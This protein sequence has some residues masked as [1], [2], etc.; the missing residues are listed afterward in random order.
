MTVK[1]QRDIA[2]PA[3]GEIVSFGDFQVVAG[4]AGEG[5]IRLT[6]KGEWTL[7]AS[8]RYR[9]EEVAS[10]RRRLY[11]E[12]DPPDLPQPKPQ[13]ISVIREEYLT[14][15]PTQDQQ[16]GRDQCPSDCHKQGG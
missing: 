10:A 9:G 2:L 14:T 13:T 6:K 15:G 3:G 1:H 12:E 11:V 8:V 4:H 7:R 16:W 5:K